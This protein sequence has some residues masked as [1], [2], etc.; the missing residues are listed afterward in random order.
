MG[1]PVVTLTGETMFERLSYSILTNTGLSDLCARTR[2]EYV[3]IAL[4]LAADPARRA[5]LRTNLRGML[6]ASPLGQTK[7]FAADF[8]DMI[9]SAVLRA[10]AS[11]KVPSAT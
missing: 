2:E 5:A 11:G 4:K 9:E 8:Y 10:R 1:V 3:E 7:Q 6:K